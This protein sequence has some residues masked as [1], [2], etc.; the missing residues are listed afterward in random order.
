MRVQI[1]ENWI[2]QRKRW[3]EPLLL[4]AVANNPPL[5]ANLGCV[6][7]GKK[8]ACLEQNPSTPPPLPPAPP[9]SAKGATAQKEA[10]AAAVTV[11]AASSTGEQQTPGVGISVGAHVLVRNISICSIETGRSDNTVRRAIV[12]CEGDTAHHWDVCFEDDDTDEADVAG[13]RLALDAGGTRDVTVSPLNPT[14][15]WS[16]LKDHL[17]V[18]VCACA[19]RVPCPLHTLL[20]MPMPTCLPQPYL[21]PPT[22]PSPSHADRDSSTGGADQRR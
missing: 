1:H 13:A 4:L 9:G 14:E 17:A 5:T 21:L 15:A 20:P 8:M 11:F 7:H 3:R 18:K 12:E 10:A 19:P 22:A 2:C 16:V 6:P